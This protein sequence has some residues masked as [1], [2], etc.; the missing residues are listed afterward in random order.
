MAVQPIV[1]TERNRVFAYEALVRGPKGE[2]AASVLSAV[3][4]ENRYA[5][6]QNCRVKAITLASQLGI[7]E[8]NPKLSINFMPGAVY[9]PAACVRLT[10]ATARA[11]SLPLDRLIFEFTEAE[12]IDSPT[13]LQQIADEYSRHGF[14]LAIDDFGAGFSNVN[15]LARLHTGIVKLDMD[16]TRDLHQRPRA[17]AI[18]RSLVRLCRGFG[19][20]IVGEGVETYEEYRAMRSCGIRL[21]QGYLLAKPAF[22]QLPDFEIPRPRREAVPMLNVPSVLTIL[23]SGR[24][25]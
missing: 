5:F 9:S 16:L 24:A 15:L 25:A 23:P 6:D 7:V 2:G 4:P 18:V 19:T 21:M 14:T 17:Q 11:H 20:Q 3:T 13:H 8:R 22:E 1:D 10:L 12:Q